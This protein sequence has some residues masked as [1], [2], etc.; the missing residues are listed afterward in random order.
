MHA[1]E[2]AMFN[3]PISGPHTTYRG[4]ELPPGIFVTYQILLGFRDGEPA[5][6]PTVKVHRKCSCEYKTL[7][8]PPFSKL[9]DVR[10]DEIQLIR[11]EQRWHLNI[12]S[13]AAIM[14]GDPLDDAV[15]WKWLKKFTKKFLHEPMAGENE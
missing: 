1:A 10:V 5:P 9:Y 11:H 15:F 3:Y 13:H 12:A 7:G 4:N 6:V 2:Q 8:G 14:L